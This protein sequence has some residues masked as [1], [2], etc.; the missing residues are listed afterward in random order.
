MNLDRLDI[1]SEAARR[2]QDWK[3]LKH[4]EHE[5][6][7]TF[8]RLILFILWISGRKGRSRRNREV[9]CRSAWRLLIRRKVSHERRLS[10]V[11]NGDVLLAE[12]II[13]LPV[14]PATTSKSKARGRHKRRDMR[15]RQKVQAPSLRM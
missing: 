1:P 13:D 7:R 4:N 2:P 12:R 11:S 5:L 8:R 10:W 9:A 15:D 14:A 3:T 6:P